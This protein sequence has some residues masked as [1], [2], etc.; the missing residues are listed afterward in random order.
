[1]HFNKTSKLVNFCI[2]I[3]IL[4]MEENKWRFWHIMLYY[5][6]KGKN[7]TETHKKHLCSLWRSL[8]PLYYEEGAVTDQM[9][10]K[11]FAR[12]HA[13]DWSLDDAPRSG[14]QVEV[15][16]DQIETLTE[17]NQCYTMWEIADILKI[18]KSIKLLVKM[19][20]V[21]FILW[22]KMKQTFWSSESFM[23]ATC[24]RD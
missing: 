3:L 2:A 12:F 7:T 11:W 17:N 18:S 22:Q 1:M 10:Q 24:H 23:Q 6:K 16:S 4:K 8:G 15:D 19:K 20:N 21:C 14:R 5:F 9:C 13:G